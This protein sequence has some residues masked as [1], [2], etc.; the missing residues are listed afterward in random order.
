MSNLQF[1]IF[2]QLLGPFMGA[3][4]GLTLIGLIAQS[5]T[6]MD[7]LVERGQSPWTLALIT[8]LG[9]PKLMSVVTP[10]ALFAATATTYSRL[11][12]E[13]ELVVGQAAGMSLFSL[14]DPALR[15]ASMCVVAIVAINLFVQPASYREMRERL[16]AIRS[17]IA[18]TLV[19]EGQFRGAADGLTIYVRRIDRGGTLN[20]LM[21]SDTRTEARPLIFEARTGQITKLNDTP[22]ILLSDGS[23]QRRQPDGTI[24]MVG[25][26]TYAFDLAAFAG[27]PGP[28][29]FKDS[30]RFLA[31][32]VKPDLT[33][34]WDRDNRNALL[35]EANLRLASPLTCLAA[36]ALA[37]LAVLGGAFSRQGYARRIAMAAFGLVML[38]LT[39][40][41][42]TSVFEAVPVLNILQY[43]LP[44][45][46]LAAAGM[47]MGWQMPKLPQTRPSS[48]KPSLALQ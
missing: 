24:Q 44:L 21:I 3:L 4:A 10:V 42:L 19:R 1:Y 7:L 46:V 26:A 15:L 47:L 13:N 14:A 8:L 12:R 2:K 20:G 22:V 23:I 35:V 41:A 30:D 45:S 18:T 39:T 36:V 48:G 17:D 37:V 31:E 11:H 5:L 40:T 38:F 34:P 25:F 28:V 32:L 16:F 6:Q 27:N 9:V 33:V 43:L 29:L